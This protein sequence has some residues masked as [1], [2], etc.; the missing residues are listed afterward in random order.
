MIDDADEA[1]GA[2]A[3]LDIGPSGFADG[4]HV[5]AVAALEEVLLGGGESVAEGRGLLHALVLAA[6]AVLLLLFFDE[7]GEG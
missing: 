3:V 2:A 7:W 6:A 1:F 4:G 5:E